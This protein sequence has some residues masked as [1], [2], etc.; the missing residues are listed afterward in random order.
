LVI[1]RQGRVAATVAGEVTY[2]GLR[3]LA[4]QVAAEAS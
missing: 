2:A 3:R 4:E 1:D